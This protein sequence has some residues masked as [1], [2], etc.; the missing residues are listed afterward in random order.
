MGAVV[1]YVLYQ[2]PSPP[3]YRE[4]TKFNN[5]RLVMV[6]GTQYN[7]AVLDVNAAKVL[8]TETRRVVLYHHGNATDIGG[9]YGL[10][11]TISNELQCHAVAFDYPCYGMT[12]RRTESVV[13]TSLSSSESWPTENELGSVAWEVFDWVIRTLA[14]DEIILWGESL[15]CFP[16]LQTAVSISSKLESQKSLPYTAKLILYAPFTSIRGMVPLGLGHL[17]LPPILSGDRC[18]NI[19]LASRCSLSTMVVHGERDEIVPYEHGKQVFQTI[20]HGRKRMISLQ[21]ASHNDLWMF[22]TPSHVYRQLKE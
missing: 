13:T 18:D 19:S 11:S 15:G 14:P 17:V 6:E 10:L 9:I 8:S 7:I 21:E 4:T 1:S 5:G 2:P 16:A 3:S 22:V 12:K 20:A